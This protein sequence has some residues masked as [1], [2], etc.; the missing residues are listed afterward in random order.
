[1]KNLTVKGNTTFNGTKVP[2]IYGGFGPDQKAMT[3]KYIAEIH[4]IEG[5][6][7]RKNIKRLEDKMKPGIDYIDLKTLPDWNGSMKLLKSLG[8]SEQELKVSK[9][10]YLFSERGYIKLVAGMSNSNTKKW[11]IMDEFI[12]QYYRMK[13]T[14]ETAMLQYERANIRRHIKSGSKENVI[15]ELNNYIDYQSKKDADTKLTALKHSISIIKDVMEDIDPNTIIGHAYS[16]IYSDA[17]VDFTERAWKLQ[18]RM[19]AGRISHL[20]HKLSTMDQSLLESL[21][22]CYD[23]YMFQTVF[24]HPFSINQQY[25]ASIDG[26][27]R[28]ARSP[29]YN[30]WIAKADRAFRDGQLD[31]LESM[32]VDPTKPMHIE[33]LFK[34]KNTQF[35]TDNLIK[36][37]LDAVVRYYKLP[38]DNKF[39]SISASKYNE[40]VE[41]E[42]Q[43]EISFAIRNLSKQESALLEPK[44][45]LKTKKK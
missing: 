39:L 41:R 38:N 35:D 36:S 21:D 14:I 19:Q 29:E 42:D 37:A 10:L 22:P 33:F 9:N 2:N 20:K 4:E 23:N 27:G 32:N 17:L 26:T 18:V 44:I 40:A 30:N 24:I 31:S 45:T 11:D 28:I 1:M 15:P 6:N 12:E 8:Y 7:L 3:D 25:R 5:F 34:V 16:A 13:E 43:G